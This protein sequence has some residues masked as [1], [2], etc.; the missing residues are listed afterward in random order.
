MY[1]T[2]IYCSYMYNV[3]IDNPKYFLLSADQHMIYEVNKC[4]DKNR[5]WFIGDSVQ[6]G[7]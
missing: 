2:Y 4:S 5:S 1:A 7:M 3:I 6:T